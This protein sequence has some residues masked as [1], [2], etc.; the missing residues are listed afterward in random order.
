ME[1]D[2]RETA[3]QIKALSWITLEGVEQATARAKILYVLKHRYS[4]V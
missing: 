3:A 4:W 1:K 2:M